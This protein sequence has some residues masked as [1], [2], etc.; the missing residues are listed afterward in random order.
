[1]T[2]ID[3]EHAALLKKVAANTNDQIAQKVYADWLM[4]HNN[5][6][7]VIV[8]NY[9]IQD[10]PIWCDE[11][12]VTSRGRVRSWNYRYWKLPRLDGVVVD[13][14]VSDP[15]SRIKKILNLYANLET[16]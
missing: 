7:W 4:E 3:S 14:A 9:R 16:V 1:M 11:N 2:P 13:P 12:G 5:P 6:G 8:L 15:R 10:W